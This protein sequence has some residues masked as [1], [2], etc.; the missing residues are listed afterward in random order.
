MNLLYILF[1]VPA[2]LFLWEYWCAVVLPAEAR[3]ALNRGDR[4]A[5]TALL[6]RIIR[7][8]TLLRGPTR[9]NARFRLS[10]IYLEE[11]QYAAA[12]QQC[13]LMLEA[14]PGAAARVNIRRRLA[15]CLEFM[16]DPDTAS[17][18]RQLAAKE[19]ETGGKTVDRC[20]SR[21]KE[22]KRMQRHTEA[23][24]A[25]EQ[26]LELMPAA[27]EQQRARV[28]VSLALASFDAG[29]PANTVEWAERAL[30]HKMEPSL[31]SMAHRVAGLGCS[32]LGRLDQSQLHYQQALEVAAAA[33]HLA[34]MGKNI[35]QLAHV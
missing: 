17:R 31:L 6:Q 7:N 28:M 26:A 20:L 4:A 21:A 2:A 18:E 35:A 23:C 30:L 13:R 19:L 24:A 1:V 9:E 33:G 32:N 15:D 8:P 27:M 12:A 14:R 29:V 5:E 25:Y 34:E 16:G 11:G 3:K 10:G 22:L